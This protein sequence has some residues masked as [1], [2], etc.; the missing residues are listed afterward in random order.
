MMTNNLIENKDNWGDINSEKASRWDIPFEVLKASIGEILQFFMDYSLKQVYFDVEKQEMVFL[1]KATERQRSIAKYFAGNFF[2]NGLVNNRETRQLFYMAMLELRFAEYLHD[3]YSKSGNWEIST[4]VSYLE[5]YLSFLHNVC[6]YNWDFRF[7]AYQEGLQQCFIDLTAILRKLHTHIWNL[8][9]TINAYIDIFNCSYEKKVCIYSWHSCYDAYDLSVRLNFDNMK[10][11]NLDEF[12]KN[13][14][15]VME[16][17]IKTFHSPKWV[18]HSGS[19]YGQLTNM[20]NL[21]E[22]PDDD[23]IMEWLKNLKN[24]TKEKHSGEQIEQMQEFLKNREENKTKLK[25]AII[26]QDEIIDKI[27]PAILNNYIGLNKRP[28]SFLFVW[29]SWVGKTQLAIEI[30]EM[31][32]VKPMIV[33]MGNLEHPSGMSSLLWAPPGYIGMYDTIITED[34]H[35]Y[36]IEEQENEPQKKILPVLVFDEIEKASPS[37]FNM[38][39]E[40]LDRGTI[41]LNKWKTLDF[42]N[43]LVILT[44]NTGAKR[45]ETIGFSFAQSDEE[46]QISNK[47]HY[48]SEV[49]KSFLPEIINRL[50]DILVFNDLT[51]ADYKKIKDNV[52]EKTLENLGKTNTFFKKVLWENDRKRALLKSTIQESLEKEVK[53]I[54]NI[55]LIEKTI[56]GVILKFLLDNLS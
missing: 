19:L 25:S 39:L 20:V 36:I 30:S 24:R 13:L 50:D 42:S 49:K 1:G 52:V 44:S 31:L 9:E 15:R 53:D 43:A 48:V 29:S 27:F 10:L 12:Y 23:I 16:L 21:S 45:G 11:E 41:T 18:N 22:L 6:S 32:W 8:E 34:Y 17:Y 35:N 4:E 46:R 55:R 40:L 26:G 47:E 54:T 14:E 51:E 33:N 28:A 37:I 38:W 3:A 2:E 7:S 5:A 56:E